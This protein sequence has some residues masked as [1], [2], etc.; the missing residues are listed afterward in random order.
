MHDRW[1][2]SP[3]GASRARGLLGGSRRAEGPVNAESLHCR[4]AAEASFCAR[5]ADSANP[6]PTGVGSSAAHYASPAAAETGPRLVKTSRAGSAFQAGA[7]PGSARVFPSCARQARAG[8][9]GS[10]GG[11]KRPSGAR[12]TVGGQRKP[13]PSG[14]ISSGTGSAGQ[15]GLH[16]SPRQECARLAGLA[17]AGNRC[18]KRCRIFPCQARC[19]GPAGLQACPREVP[20]S[21]ALQACT[22]NRGAQRRAVQACQTGLARAGKRSSH[23]WR[24][25][26]SPTQGARIR[27]H[28]PCSYRVRASAARNAQA[29]RGRPQ[30]GRVRP[31]GTLD[32]AAGQAGPADRRVRASLTYSARP[33]SRHRRVL[34]RITQGAGI[35]L[36]GG[37]YGAQKRPGCACQ[38]LA[39]RA[40]LT[41]RK[42]PHKSPNKSIHAP[43]IPGV[44]TQ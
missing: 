19:T 9:V 44:P 36:V 31:S 3:E 1:R 27:Q 2:A 14:V 12:H 13:C 7:G 40:P 43:S 33:S 32:A 26:A 34:A 25:G 4:A 23:G 35:V 29:G 6:C 17:G 18:R 24:V 41:S 39:G 5:R 15:T 21:L 20:P 38:G 10:G 16:A 8:K 37:A 42:S 28:R 30:S 11:R 22:C